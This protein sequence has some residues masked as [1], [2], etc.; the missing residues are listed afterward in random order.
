MKLGV[1]KAVGTT[2]FLGL[3]HLPAFYLLCGLTLLPRYVYSL[4]S[5]H[6]ELGQVLA[7]AGW[8]NDL[9]TVVET[10]L[11]AFVAAVMVWT[12][13]RDRQEE[14]WTVF[15]ALGDAFERTPTIL[16]VAIVF[17]V[18]STVLTVVMDV[19]GEVMPL[20]ALVP[21]LIALVLALVLALVFPCAAVDND[22]VLDCFVRSAALTSGSRLRILLVYFLVSIPLVLVALIY[23]LIAQPDPTQM[24]SL[25]LSLL[26]LGGPLLSLFPMAAQVAMHEQLAEL[27]DGLEFSETVA[28]FD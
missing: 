20:A 26:F 5:G 27:E 16:G 17:A 25:P 19:L 4:M 11:G 14:S 7:T 28:V 3:R 15:T 13:I 1:F 2:Y 9:L 24:E 10:V 12:L 21:M 18:G 23:F 6:S 22:G 8:Q